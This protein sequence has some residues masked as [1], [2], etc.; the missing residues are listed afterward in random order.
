MHVMR[1]RAGGIRKGQDVRIHLVDYPS[2]EFGFIS[3][4]VDSVSLVPRDDVYLV[5]VRLDYPLLTSE[6]KV[7]TLKQELIGEAIILT[8]ERRL[9]VRLFDEFRDAFAN[10]TS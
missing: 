8:D 1:E 6:G 4:S 2:R 10:A 7:I 5:S 9:L 3:G